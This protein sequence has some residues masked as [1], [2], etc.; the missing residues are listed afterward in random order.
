MLSIFAIQGD[1][2]SF[3]LTM[4]GYTALVFLMI[5]LLLAGSFL[6]GKF[7]G[8]QTRMQAKQLAFSAM[9]VALAMAASM[10][11]IWKMPMGG[12]VT[13]LSM[14]FIVLVGHWWGLSA[15][16]TAAL[17]YGVLQLIVDPYILSLPQMLVDYLFA[18]GALGLSGL[19]TQNELRIGKLRFPGL[20][21]GYMVAVF[22]RF[23]FAVLSG[24]IF[25]GAYTPEEFASPLLYS[26]VYN[27]SYLLAES[28]LT[29]VVVCMPPVRRA[30]G[31]VR[32]MAVDEPAEAMMPKA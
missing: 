11:K 22:G 8:K 15:G 2:G 25:F 21:A 13:L 4:P 1:D 5:A 18:F 30:L 7:L 19:F 10:I 32:N 12:S 28:A 23:V 31:I 27:G 14:L 16:L 6:F 3:A 20:V 24:V 26:I 17:A 29:I 9:A